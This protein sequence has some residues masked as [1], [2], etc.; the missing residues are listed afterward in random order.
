MSKKTDTKAAIEQKPTE[1]KEIP[2]DA[3]RQSI[4]DTLNDLGAEP[5]VSKSTFDLTM[6]LQSHV[7]TMR[8]SI[9]TQ[10]V[11]RSKVWLKSIKT[12]TNLTDEDFLL[13][14]HSMGVADIYLS[15]H[16]A[17]DRRFYV[18]NDIDATLTKEQVESRVRFSG[19]NPLATKEIFRRVFKRPEHMKRARNSR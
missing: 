17:G 16:A 9:V 8:K 3:N 13:R 14:L 5:D 15:E 7:K 10:E 6:D 4:I 2:D 11:D 12:Q 18:F 1:V 19:I